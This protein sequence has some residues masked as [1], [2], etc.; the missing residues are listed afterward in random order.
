MQQKVFG[1]KKFEHQ[2]FIPN[3]FYLK[4]ISHTCVNEWK[5]LFFIAEAVVTKC[6]SKMIKML[7][8]FHNLLFCLQSLIK[9]W[10]SLQCLSHCCHNNGK[11]IALSM[12]Q[13]IESLM[14][15]NFFYSQKKSFCVL[16]VD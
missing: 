15:R 11:F 9:K 12:G 5:E 1:N 16:C 10:I 14:A 6:A 13:K 4:T 2:A 8:F 7:Y 3:Q